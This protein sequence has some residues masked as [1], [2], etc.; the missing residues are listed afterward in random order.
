MPLGDQTPHGAGLRSRLV[1]I[2]QLSSENA[3]GAFPIETWTSLALEWMSKRDLRADERFAA[4][5]TSAFAETE[6]QMAYRS[7]M[8]PDLLDVT[9]MRRLVYEGR[10]HDIV[11]A[12]VIGMQRGVTMLTL[13]GGRS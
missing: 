1:T 13:A 9:K 5:Q 8:D 4:N 7:D 2:E 11:A 3:G 6:W 10:T 12:S